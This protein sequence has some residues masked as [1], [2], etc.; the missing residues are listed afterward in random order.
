MHHIPITIAS[1]RSQ[2][3]EHA[4]HKVQVYVQIYVIIFLETL[5]TLTT[6]VL[7]GKLRGFKNIKKLETIAI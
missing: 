4:L 7:D 3:F 1:R 6:L 2:M 5:V